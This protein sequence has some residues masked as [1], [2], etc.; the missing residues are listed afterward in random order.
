[1]ETE[2]ISKNG[3]SSKSHTSRK[4]LIIRY[5]LL[6]LVA[7]ISLS[8]CSKENDRETTYTF[9]FNMDASGVTVSATVYEYSGSG[10]TVGQRTFNC[11]KGFSEVVTVS[12]KAEKVK[13]KLT[14]KAGSNTGVVWVKQIYYL[15]KGKNVNIEVVGATTVVEKEP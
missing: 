3:A 5:A 7:V 1:M 13:V 2:T 4:N 11:V 10:E 12:S 9:K 14:L 6:T 8:S 15:E